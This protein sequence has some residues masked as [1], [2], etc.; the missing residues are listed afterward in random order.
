MLVFRSQ[1]AAARIMPDPRIFN[2]QSQSTRRDSDVLL[3]F[4]QT[5]A[6]VTVL[7]VYRDERNA[8]PFLT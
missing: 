4:G 3:F 7:L 6:L 8:Y 2:V 5:L 1:V